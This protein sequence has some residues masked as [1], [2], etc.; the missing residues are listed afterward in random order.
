[1]LS[2]K[3]RGDANPLLLIDESDVTAGHAASVGRM[4]ATQ[5]YYLMS[6]GLCEKVARRLV[7]RGF[8]GPILAQIPHQVVRESIIE[9]IERQLK[10]AHQ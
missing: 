4:N 10:D 5:L 1:M 8:M 2:K 9:D 6:R 7:I 3:A